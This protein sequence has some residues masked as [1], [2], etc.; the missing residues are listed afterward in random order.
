MRQRVILGASSPR[1]WIVR[2]CK[3]IPSLLKVEGN[4]WLLSSRWQIRANALIMHLH[5][6]ADTFGAHPRLDFLEFVLWLEVH[7]VWLNIHAR[8]PVLKSAH[9]WF[10]I[11]WIFW[12]LFWHIHVCQ[13]CMFPLKCFQNWNIW[14][15][16]Y[17]YFL[18]QKVC[19]FVFL[20]MILANNYSLAILSQMFKEV[21]I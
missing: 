1:K 17:F 9:H 5:A 8:Q 14:H 21:Q 7:D 13:F 3:D 16:V 2:T 12:V 10:L 11:Q 15:F 19:Y 4:L 20:F 18:L 6:F